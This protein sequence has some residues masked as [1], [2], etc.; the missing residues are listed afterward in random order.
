MDSEYAGLSKFQSR[1]LFAYELLSPPSFHIDAS[2]VVQPRSQ[3]V[4]LSILSLSSDDQGQIT[5]ST[6]LLFETFPS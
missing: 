3:K 1:S 2:S 5:G 4:L 6:S